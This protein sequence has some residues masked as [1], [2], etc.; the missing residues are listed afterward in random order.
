MDAFLNFISYF[1]PPMILDNKTLSTELGNWTPDQIYSK[2]GILTRHISEPNQFSSDLAVESFKK[3]KQDYPLENIKVDYIIYVTQTPEYLIPSGSF[4][5][6]SKLGLN[7]PSTDISAGCSGFMNAL[8]L[9]KSLIIAKTFSNILIITTET[10]SK[11][12]HPHD[13]SV[14]TLFGD[15]ASASIVSNSPKGYK[16]GNFD[17]GTLPI[18]YQKLILPGIGIES[19]RKPNLDNLITDSNGYVRTL[20]NIYMDGP[21]IMS[22]TL[23]YIPR[24]INKTLLINNISSIKNLDHIILH[25]ASLFVLKTL[26]FKLNLSESQNFI[27]N[28]EDKG[29]TVSSTIP[30]ALKENELAFNSKNLI[31]LSGFGVGLSWATC[32]IE[33]V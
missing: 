9:A 26:K 31:L 7:L 32:I 19:L 11:I 10:Y 13:K 22:F 12:I 6:Q 16:I 27:I 4:V 14:R 8:F 25:Q 24:S 15:G 33:K 21:A 1:L 3:L 2:T 17:I 30:I 5:F 20:K 29:N 18:D 28:L 23:D